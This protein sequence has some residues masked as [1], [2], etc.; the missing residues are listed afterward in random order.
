MSRCVS[1]A[2]K[3][4][5]RLMALLIALS[6]IAGCWRIVRLADETRENIPFDEAQ[7]LVPFAVQCPTYLPTGVEPTPR[8]TYHAEF[9]DPLDSEVRLIFG[10][11]GGQEALVEIREKHIADRV[12][13][14]LLDRDSSREGTLRYLIAWVVGWPSVDETRPQVS[15]SASSCRLEEIP[16]TLFEITG[17]RALRANLIVWADNP[18]AFSVYTRLPADE[19]HRVARSVEECA[20]RSQWQ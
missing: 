8:V 19:A 16:C 5:A 6:G 13:R 18:T 3:G 12:E 4:A 7:R 10:R 20:A 17:P 9:G 2:M 11:S 15:T 1:S 14:N